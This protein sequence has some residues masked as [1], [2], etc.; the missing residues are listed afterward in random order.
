LILRGDSTLRGHVF[1]EMTCLGL[2]RGVGLIVPAFP[3]AGRITRD[4]V[5]HVR[6]GTQVCNVADT[7]FARGP[8]FGFRARTMRD[9]VAET[10]G[11]RPVTLVRLAALRAGGA[12]ALSVAL[13]NAPDG[14]VV[15]PDAETD[16][17]IAV[18][19]AGYAA[20][21]HRRRV[22]LRCA[23]PLAALAAGTPGRPVTD[24]I[25]ARRLL[26]VCG[27]HTAAATAQL[28]ALATVSLPRLV[29]PSAALWGPERAAALS[30]VV[31]AARGQLDRYGMTVVTTERIRSV[32]H[33]SQADGAVVMSALV[34][35]AAL[36]AP[37]VDAV[38]TKGGI[39]SADVVTRALRSQRARVVGQIE[40]GISLWTTA[41]PW[42]GTVPVA[43]VPGNIGD[44]G[45]LLRMAD[46]F[47]H[48]VRLG[49]S[50]PSR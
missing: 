14:G 41:P 34:E 42:G 17:D 7:E 23:A 35:V 5:H 37:E 18:I 31:D 24:R 2:D 12:S 38:V 29:V 49:R 21:R 30:G 27:S 45:T 36:L 1:A 16:G 33:H 44:D 26:V 40:T 50:R 46:L 9:W 8:A 3:E 13:L 47:G 10:G 15:I 48:G 25:S 6:I 43:I 19:A 28:D 32:A 11:P 20:A 4:G 22:V 39:T